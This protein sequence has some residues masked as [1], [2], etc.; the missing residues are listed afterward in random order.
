MTLS[1]VEQIDFESLLFLVHVLYYCTVFVFLAI[2]IS[3]VASN[4]MV[5][6][7]KEYERKRIVAI[8]EG[9]ETIPCNSCGKGHLNTK[10]AKICCA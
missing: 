1:G 8:L 3:K 9:K 4:L 2:A 5:S 10:K 6:R 7:N